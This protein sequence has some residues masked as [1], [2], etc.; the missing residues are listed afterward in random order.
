MTVRPKRRRTPQIVHTDQIPL[1]RGRSLLVQRAGSQQVVRVGQDAPQW[2][3]LYHHLLT[4]SWWEFILASLAFYLAANALFG[5][6]YLFDPAGI[7]NARPDSL[8][9]AF[10]FSVQTFAT[11]GYGTMYPATNYANWVMTAESYVGLLSVAAMTGMVFARISRPTARVRFAKVAVIASHDGR[12]TL[13]LRMG[14]ERTTQIVDAT[15]TLSVL[16][17]RTTAEGRF[18]RRFHDLKL[19][20]AKTPV[21][22]ISF[23]A[24]HTIDEHSPLYQ[25]TAE[26]LAAD[27][28]ELLVTVTGLEESLGSTVHARASFIDS[29]ILL[30]QRYVDIFG[31]TDDGRRGIDYAKFDRTEPDMP[32]DAAR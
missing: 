25:L 7:A 11:V 13:M 26:D 2:R 31:L 14:N 1:T 29:E 17:S 15:I 4:L 10:F 18:M 9:D 16:R 32:V 6:L 12:P 19:V 23:T 22:S 30:G 21:F 5:V 8:L 28:I 27:E 20:R 24:M 3:D